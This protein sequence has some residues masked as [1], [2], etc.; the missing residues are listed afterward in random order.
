MLSILKF[1]IH[2]YISMVISSWF[3]LGY[4]PLKIRL[5]GQGISSVKEIKPEDF[6]NGD[7]QINYIEKGSIIIGL[8]VSPSAL[9]SVGYFLNVIDTLILGLL[10]KCSTFVNRRKQVPVIISMEFID[11]KFCNNLFSSLTLSH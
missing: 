3:F 4:L 11:C 7:I 2:T 1:E 8:D 9:K 5:S 10:K 6:T